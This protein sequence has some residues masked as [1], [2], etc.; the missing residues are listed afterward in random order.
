[1]S[2]H[3]APPQPSQ[4][5]ILRLLPAAAI[6]GVV[7]AIAA[8]AF[9][10]FVEEAQHTVFHRIP[11]A[12]GLDGTPWWW[13][14]VL[15]MLGAT[16]VAVARRMPGHTGSGPLTGFHFDT[17]LPSVPSILVAALATLI[18]GFALGPE[19]PLIVVG[20]ALGMLLLRRQGEEAG[21]AGAFLGGT[22]AIGAI[23]GNPFITAFMILEF[24]AFGAAPAALIV[25]VLLALAASYLVQI[26][27]W[28]LP[29]VGTH[30]LAVPGL[31]AYDSIRPGDLLIGIAVAAVAAVVAI[32][33][34]DLGLR[35]ESVAQRRPIPALYI[36]AAL[37]AIALFVA[38]VGF[39]VDI[40]LVLFSGQ[41]GMG[42]LIAESS[43][44]VVIIVILAKT[45]AYAA[46]LGGGFRGGP[47]FPATF[48][49]V[50]V[51]VLLSLWIPSVSVSALA[52]AGIA[53]AATAMIKL[54]ATSALLGALL[55]GGA[56][57]AVAP[58]AIVGAVIGLVVRLA[59]DRRDARTAA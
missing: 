47:I 27:I 29:G 8:T 55:V 32:I 26:G 57:A 23:F 40:D 6:V 36:G 43:V 19:A 51:A 44:V 20:S 31:P 59:A 22:A 52:A 53:G 10:W 39:D 9:L 12:L 16:L 30:A 50:G 28:D 46:A 33:A 48:L 45:V 1:M 24:A 14:A 56:G 5:Q 58:F 21:K 13:T 41:S 49:G 35:F 54:P 3:P 18:F 15:L 38:K 2:A 11:D 42:G 34:R 7:G 17:P 4:A 25:P 37:T